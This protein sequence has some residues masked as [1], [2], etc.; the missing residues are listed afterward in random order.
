MSTSAK[1]DGRDVRQEQVLDLPEIAINRKWCKGCGI[2]IAVCPQDV[3]TADRDGKPVIA[4]PDLCIWC[5][6]CDM[7]C[8]DFAINLAG[9]KLW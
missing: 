1:D 9:K 7:Y 4:Q 8:P 2:C 5:E 3:Y 6:R